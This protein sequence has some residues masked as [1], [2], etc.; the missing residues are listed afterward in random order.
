MTYQPNLNCL[1]FA[2]R[3]ESYK[4]AFN[5]LSPT[6]QFQINQMADTLIASL[7]TIKPDVTFSKENALEVI[8]AL[9]MGILRKDFIIISEEVYVE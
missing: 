7:K 2:D 1:S 3:S 6:E 9:G 8:A 5:A 4:R